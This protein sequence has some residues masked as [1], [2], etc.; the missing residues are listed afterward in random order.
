MSQER[1]TRV[2]SKFKPLDTSVLRAVSPLS[3]SPIFKRRLRSTWRTSSDRSL[4][5]AGVLF[6]ERT[7]TMGRSAVAY[8]HKVAVSER[9][10]VGMN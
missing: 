1:T 5:V 7:T 10:V 8:E 3:G 2:V 4:G 6:A 9:E